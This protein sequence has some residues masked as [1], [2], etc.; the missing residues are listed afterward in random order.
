MKKE[1][2]LTVHAVRGV[3]PEMEKVWPPFSKN[4]IR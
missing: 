4:L 3:S 1:T 2:P